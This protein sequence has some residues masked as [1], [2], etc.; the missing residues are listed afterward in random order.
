MSINRRKSPWKSVSFLYSKWQ[1]FKE[2]S[3]HKEEKEHRN[4][5]RTR[6]KTHKIHSKKITIIYFS[7]LVSPLAYRNFRFVEIVGN[8]YIYVGAKID[9]FFPSF[10]PIWNAFPNSGFVRVTKILESPGILIGFF[11]ELESPGWG[12]VLFSSRGKYLGNC[13][14]QR[15]RIYFTNLACCFGPLEYKGPRFW[16][17]GM[18]LFSF[19]H[20]NTF[21][22]VS[23]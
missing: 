10:T 19:F 13:D 20:S 14:D 16:P 8:T 11:P 1:K 4:R 3:I 7:T 21:W 5:E 22:F 9:C 2:L 23:P 15:P 12:E 6:L 18:N 17:P